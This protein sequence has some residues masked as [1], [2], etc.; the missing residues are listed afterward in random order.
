MRRKQRKRNTKRKWRQQKVSIGTIQKIARQVSTYQIKKQAEPKWSNLQL[1][2][3]NADI[4]GKPITCLVFKSGLY[5]VSSGVPGFLQCSIMLRSQHHPQTVPLAVA[6]AVGAPIDTGPH[7]RIGETINMTGL[8]LKGMFIQGSTALSQTVR[9]SLCTA[10]CTLPDPRQLL[11]NLDFMTVR[12]NIDDTEKLNVVKTWELNFNQTAATEPRRR[13]FSFYVKLN[14][15][16]RYNDDQSTQFPGIQETAYQDKRY[17]LVMYSDVP[18]E[19]P[20]GGIPL[21]IPNNQLNQVQQRNIQ[22]YGRFTAYY[23]DS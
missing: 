11:P 22:F 5:K 21:N 13:P 17:Y 14:Q 23:R 3:P 4:Q 16:F 1:G 6:G 7:K 9:I 18:D 19:A 2:F 10:K 15:R 12:R 8:A 20:G